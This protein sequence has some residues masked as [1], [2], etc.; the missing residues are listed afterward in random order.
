MGDYLRTSMDDGNGGNALFKLVGGYARRMSA[1]LRDG[2]TFVFS[3][4]TRR[5]VDTLLVKGRWRY[6][7]ACMFVFAT[8][9]LFRGIS[10]R[11]MSSD[12]SLSPV[13]R[14]RE[15]HDM[16]VSNHEHQQRDHSVRSN[17]FVSGPGGQ[18]AERAWAGG[19]SRRA[20]GAALARKEPH[21]AAKVL[22]RMD[23]EESADILQGMRSDRSA[24]VAK[25]LAQDYHS[26]SL[27]E[28]SPHKEP[29]EDSLGRYI[30]DRRTE[31]G[32]Q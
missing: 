23:F 4:K 10:R 3:S 11:G 26:R 18:R 20:F 16:H 9:M 14:L 17:K 24:L 30:H 13:Q 12:P 6:W 27:E 1:K 7:Y 32:A 8:C 28:G 2:P 31:G 29:E 22:A 19:G 15:R 21:E 5:T 25:Y